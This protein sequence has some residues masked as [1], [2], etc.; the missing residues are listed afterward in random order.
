MTVKYEFLVDGTKFAAVEY[1]TRFEP[2]F[3]WINSLTPESLSL[4]AFRQEHLPCL[5]GPAGVGEG[6]LTADWDGS[7]STLLSNG[8]TA[9]NNVS[10]DAGPSDA[11]IIQSADRFKR[12]GV[13][14]HGG[15][16]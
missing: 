6:K 14:A 7:S 13:G 11:T 9:L 10:H 1:N 4:G 12:R 3:S 16:P 2:V 5:V 8:Y 15:P